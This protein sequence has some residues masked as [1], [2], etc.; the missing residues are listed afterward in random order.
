MEEARRAPCRCLPADD[1]RNIRYRA[2]K[3]D[4]AMAA[5]LSGQ[6]DFLNTESLLE[7]NRAALTIAVF[8]STRIREPKAAYRQLE[9]CNTAPPLRRTEPS[10]R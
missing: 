9:S 8:G 3:P 5:M 4:A 10:R 7:D 6:F 1:A 2:T